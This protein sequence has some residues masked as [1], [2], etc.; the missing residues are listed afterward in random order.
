M[1][2]Y[3]YVYVDVDVY[4]LYIYI[5]CILGIFHTNLGHKIMRFKER[6]PFN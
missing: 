5:I 4:T 6:N 1:Y 2:Y 3:V